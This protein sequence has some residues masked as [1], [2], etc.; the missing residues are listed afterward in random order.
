MTNE[1]NQYQNMKLTGLKMWF[2]ERCMII[3]TITWRR[4]RVTAVCYWVV[5]GVLDTIRLITRMR[6]RRTRTGHRRRRRRR[7]ST[8]HRHPRTPTA[9]TRPCPVSTGPEKTNVEAPSDPLDYVQIFTLLLN[10]CYLQLTVLP[11]QK[12]RRYDDCARVIQ[13][14]RCLSTFI[15]TAP[16]KLK[17]LELKMWFSM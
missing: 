13:H 16:L 7:W 5:P 3:I 12:L 14:P 6:R 17:M 10:Q 1:Q 4:R 8:R 9:R 15:E 11:T 2:A